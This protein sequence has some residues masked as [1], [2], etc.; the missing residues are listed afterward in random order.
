MRCCFQDQ[1]QTGCAKRQDL[2]TLKGCWSRTRLGKYGKLSLVP[3]GREN[4]LVKD[5]CRLFLPNYQTSTTRAEGPRTGQTRTLPCGARTLDAS[6]FDL[7]WRSYFLT[8]QFKGGAMP[9][10]VAIVVAIIVTT[11][12]V[13]AATLAWVDWYSHHGSGGVK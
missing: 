5:L 9:Q 4:S 6:Q 3:R 10:D 13:F 2:E 7:P 12:S 8:R 1:S 11:F